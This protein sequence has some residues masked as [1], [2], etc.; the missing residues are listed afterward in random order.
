ML[1]AN[2]IDVYYQYIMNLLPPLHPPKKISVNTSVLYHC[3]LKKF[4]KNLKKA[5]LRKKIYNQDGSNYIL[6][7]SYGNVEFLLPISLLFPT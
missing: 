4:N 3:C 5:D 2:S 1:D 6:L 7:F